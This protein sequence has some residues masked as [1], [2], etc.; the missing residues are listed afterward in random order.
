MRI[1]HQCKNMEHS[2]PCFLPRLIRCTLLTALIL[3]GIIFLWHQP[4]EVGESTSGYGIYNQLIFSTPTDSK[5]LLSIP[6]KPPGDLN[7]LTKA[8]ILQR[9]EALAREFPSIIPSTYRP[10]PAVFSQIQDN[11]PWWGLYGIY[12]YG[13][14]TKAIEGPSA[15]SSFVLNPLLLIGLDEANGWITSADP[16]QYVNF[17]PSP[18]RAQFNITKRLLEIDYRVSGYF[19]YLE[20]GVGTSQRQLHINTINARDFGYRFLA[21][22]SHASVNFLSLA[23]NSNHPIPNIEFI[24][25]GGSCGY[26]GGCNNVS[27]TQQELI[28]TVPT[29][30]AMGTVKLWESE[31]SSISNRA[32][33]TVVLHLK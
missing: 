33:V 6:I 2:L 26:A 4:N 16:R 32:D 29:L 15:R 24:H 1:P 25:C 19:K 22:D 13:S 27:P 11:R 3:L 9:R 30:P 21:V 28:I 18:E 17:Y 14:G 23:S 5:G 20:H 31:P 7:W 8:E 12:F 10:S